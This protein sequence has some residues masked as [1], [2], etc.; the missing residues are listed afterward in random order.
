MSFEDFDRHFRE[1]LSAH[2]TP[3]DTEGLWKGVEAGLDSRGKGAALW[4]VT[5][6]AALIIA[7]ALMTYLLWPEP[8]PVQTAQTVGKET[9]AV[10]ALTD[11]SSGAGS[12]R[13]NTSPSDPANTTEMT[14]PESGD[15]KKTPR[16]KNEHGH[17]VTQ[18][19][20]SAENRSIAEVQKSE[21][22]D[23][24]FTMQ[25]DPD[26]IPKHEKAGTSDL[27]GLAT[28]R[29]N[30]PLASKA[31]RDHRTTHAQEGVSSR[32]ADEVSENTASDASA[33]P[34]TSAPL[35]LPRIPGLI[36]VTASSPGLSAERGTL[37]DYGP[38]PAHSGFF[39][40]AEFGIGGFDRTFV[41][42]HD[43]ARH[44]A[45]QRSA[46]EQP[47][48]Y[49]TGQV[50]FGKRYASGF[51]WR[52]GIA[53]TRINEHFLMDHTDTE[54]TEY[55]V[56]TG[57]HIDQAGDTLFTHGTATETTVTHSYM[58][59][60][61]SYTL[62][63]IPLF[64]GWAKDFGC[65]S[66]GAE[67]G[68]FANVRTAVRGSALL[69][70]AEVVRIED[71]ELYEPQLSLSPAV[72]GHISYRV[73]AR[74]SLFAAPGLRFIPEGNLSTGDIGHRMLLFGGNLGVGYAF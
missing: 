22:A 13:E 8:T 7:G 56:V 48:E 20:G 59:H 14:A 23:G 16:S 64:A 63:D 30:P 61:N 10:S 34:P 31:E 69:A 19:P 39:A 43:N 29:F 73:G 62:I 42:L 46:T 3:T 4:W 71:A 41:A 44:R 38:A 70:E 17:L 37:P 55:T 28:A 74:W 11:E 54:V 27:P 36:P 58:S 49:L 24:A 57:M 12:S 52:T 6:A 32:G 40:R 53:L 35:T 15:A 68:V 33:L 65:W 9:E 50:S 18:R 5:G 60:Y 72:N 25:H 45:D 2:H 26:E 66:L 21:G 1:K 51:F 47:L 67:V